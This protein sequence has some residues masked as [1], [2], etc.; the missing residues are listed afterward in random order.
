MVNLMHMGMESK[1]A[2]DIM[3]FTRKG[4]FKD[5]KDLIPKMQ[6]SNVPQWYID[7]CL[8]ISYMFPKAH[9]AAYVTM[10][11]RIAWFKVYYPIAFYQTYFTVRADLFDST[12]MTKGIERVRDEIRRLKNSDEKLSATNQNILTILE[13]V[14]EMYTRGYKFLP[15][16]LYKSDAKVFLEENGDILPPLNAMA[17]LGE[18]AALAIA[19][20]RKNGEFLSVE[21][22]RLRSGINKTAL[23]VLRL[24][25]CLDG[26]EESDQMA[27]FSF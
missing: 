20:A 19:E 2:F 18:N 23:E 27:F 14:N 15:V 10:A 1:D 6:E 5:H 7:S 21:D 24:E 3:E 11:F 9:A 17:G 22:L 25:G 4:K 16:D 12:I 8:K 13:V 26:M